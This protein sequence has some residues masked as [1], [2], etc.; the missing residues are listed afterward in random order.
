MNATSN[1]TSLP[2]VAASRRRDEPLDVLGLEERGFTAWP[3]PQN[4]Y[5]GGWVFR[6]GGGFTKRANSA[7]ALG[8]RQ[9]LRS[10]SIN[11]WTPRRAFSE[12][13][14]EAEKLYESKGLPTIFRLTPLAGADVD[15][16]LAA[17]GYEAF[18]PS[19]VMTAPLPTRAVGDDV[20]VELGPTPAWLNGVT[21]ANGVAPSH[22]QA[23]D[24]IVQAIALPTAC[25]TWFCDG[26][27]AGFGMAVLDRGFV[28]LFDIVVFGQARG[29]G[30][31]RRLTD[32]LL[33]WGGAS[34]ATA[35]YLQVLKANKVARG[36]YE[37]FGFSEAYR[38]HYRQRAFGSH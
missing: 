34:G 24:R 25:A 10:D 16:T 5:F 19:L 20:R 17:A 13:R 2:L 29:R 36:L 18:D 3:A 27:P 32:A 4:V 11:A 15:P 1:A 37:S 22:R 31:G 28:G 12:V 26:R 21:A 9:D 6:L 23:H 38:Y 14:A 30:G 35:A 7:N 8:D 33:A